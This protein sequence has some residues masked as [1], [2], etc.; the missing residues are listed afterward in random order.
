[1]S[2]HQSPVSTEVPS[3]I[4]CV[5]NVFVL[6][7]DCIALSG[8]TEPTTFSRVLLL[9]LLSDVVPDA[10]HV[11]GSRREGPGDA[12]ST[13]F[14]ASWDFASEQGEAPPDIGTPSLCRGESRRAI[15]QLL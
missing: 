2:T 12:S 13:R 9:N 1:M 14:E 15:N 10:A 11:R 7:A 8:E 6:S 4:P 3:L 5:L